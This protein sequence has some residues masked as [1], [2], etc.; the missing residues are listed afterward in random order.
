MNIVANT[1]HS[2]VNEFSG[3]L[4]LMEYMCL[5]TSQGWGLVHGS[6]PALW[7]CKTEVCFWQAQFAYYELKRYLVYISIHMSWLL[8]NCCLL[9]LFTC[10]CSYAWK[11]YCTTHFLTLISNKTF[12]NLTVCTHCELLTLASEYSSGTVH[13]S[14]YSRPF[15]RNHSG[16]EIQRCQLQNLHK[17]QVCL[18]YDVYHGT[19]TFIYCTGVLLTFQWKLLKQ[20]AAIHVTNLQVIFSSIQ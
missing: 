11:N 15:A 9:L 16:P 10:Y 18:Y 13:F 19:Y 6:H 8:L 2:I 20:S 17:T 3:L 14:W 12:G 4:L 1:L 7:H 5:W